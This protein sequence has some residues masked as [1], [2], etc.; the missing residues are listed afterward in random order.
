MWQDEI[1]DEIHKFRE[2]HAKYFNYDLDAMFTDW[3]QRQGENGRKVVSFS[4]KVSPKP[5]QSSSPPN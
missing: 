2:E 3:Q 5:S 1:L 4:R